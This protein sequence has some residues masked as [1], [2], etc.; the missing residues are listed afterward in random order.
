MPERRSSSCNTERIG[1]I[2]QD[3]HLPGTRLKLHYGDL[4]DGKGLLNVTP[5]VEPDEVYNLGAQSHVRVG[6]P[7]CGG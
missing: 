3:P 6:A 1:H 7:G 5:M 2:H 4:N